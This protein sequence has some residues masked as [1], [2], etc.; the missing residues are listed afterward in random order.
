MRA[1]SLLGHDA[2][3]FAVN[4]RATGAPPAEGEFPMDHQFAAIQQNIQSGLRHTTVGM[5]GIKH[6]SEVCVSI[7]FWSVM[8]GVQDPYWVIASLLGRFGVAGIRG[9]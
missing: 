7:L 9:C 1:A 3:C 5:L 6:R 4:N 2:S 8:L